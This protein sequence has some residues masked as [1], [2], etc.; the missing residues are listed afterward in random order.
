MYIPRTRQVLMPRR[1]YRM[2]LLPIKLRLMN[3][4]INLIFSGSRILLPQNEES[5]QPPNE[6]ARMGKS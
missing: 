5:D 6:T 2:Y 4:L 3:E 1:A